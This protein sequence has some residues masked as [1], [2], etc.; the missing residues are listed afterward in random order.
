M[1]VYQLYICF[2]KTWSENALQAAS[3]Y[4][5]LSSWHFD[6]YNKVPLTE[7]SRFTIIIKMIISSNLKH[8]KTFSKY[9]L[10]DHPV[11]LKISFWSYLTLLLTWDLQSNS[12]H[13]EG[14]KCVK[15]ICVTVYD[16]VWAHLVNLIRQAIPDHIRSSLPVHSTRSGEICDSLSG[17]AVQP[18]GLWTSCPH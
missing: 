10:R 18:G 2:M 13:L 3:L 1:N 7:N 15:P 6:I 11:Q 8:F 5:L 16:C 14:K 4:K 9:I 17:E 12:T